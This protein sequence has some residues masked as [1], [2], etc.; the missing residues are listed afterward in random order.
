MIRLFC[1]VLSKRLVM[2]VLTKKTNC[3]VPV[4]FLS[5]E[6]RVAF[7]GESQLRYPNYGACWVF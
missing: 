3:I 5:R 7:Y 6:I 4:G 1:C 2:R